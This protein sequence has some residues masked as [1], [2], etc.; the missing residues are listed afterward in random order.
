[1]YISVSIYLCSNTTL[2]RKYS[3]EF[4][5]PVLDSTSVAWCGCH[6]GGL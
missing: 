6:R 2:L 1:M 5:W 4:R 3:I